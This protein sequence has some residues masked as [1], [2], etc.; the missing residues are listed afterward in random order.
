[1]NRNSVEVSRGVEAHVSLA[2]RPEV[3]NERI[4]V[5]SVDIS[6]VCIQWGKHISIREPPMK[7]RSFPD[8]RLSYPAMEHRSR[9]RDSNGEVR[10]SGTGHRMS[11]SWKVATETLFS[12]TIEMQCRE[13]SGTL[14]VRGWCQFHGQLADTTQGNTSNRA[15]QTTRLGPC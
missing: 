9:R 15:K 12:F 5:P 2:D 8:S 3:R 6:L 7:T 11:E 13:K 10:V 14:L 1:M 4:L